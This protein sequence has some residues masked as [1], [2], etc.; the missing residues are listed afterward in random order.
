MF[1]R[2]RRKTI[3]LFIKAAVPQWEQEP[4]NLSEQI[5]RVDRFRDVAVHTNSQTTLFVAFHGMGGQR[6]D[7]RVSATRFFFL[8]YQSGRFKTTHLRHLYIHQNHVEG[9][10]LHRFQRYQS[11]LRQHH[12]VAPFL[13]QP[14][15]QPL[16]HNIVFGH[17]DRE[18]LQ[19]FPNGMSSHQRSNLGLRQIRS[20]NVEQNIT[21]LQPVEGFV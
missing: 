16:V 7:G 19:L 9:L 17:K 11:I 10:F 4:V 21:Q 1:G 3:R 20:Q 14:R 6:N 13:Q 15:N 5:L 18:R 8:A 2:L 12:C